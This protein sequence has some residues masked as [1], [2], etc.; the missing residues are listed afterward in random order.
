MRWRK[1]FIDL[2]YYA[3]L[4]LSITKLFYLQV[5]EIKSSW[6]RQMKFFVAIYEYKYR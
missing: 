4:T 2:K 3:N 5:V 6:L 1:L